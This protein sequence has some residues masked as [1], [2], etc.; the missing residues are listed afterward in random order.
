MFAAASFV[1]YVRGLAAGVALSPDLLPGAT[2]VFAC[3]FMNIFV[4]AGIVGLT[5]LLGR[6]LSGAATG[7]LAAATVAIVPLSVDTTV[8]VRNDPGMSSW[9]SSR[10][11]CMR[12]GGPSTPRRDTVAHL[13][14]G[15]WQE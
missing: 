8:L 7:L 9:F 15:C 14:R 3:R 5:G 6:R 12:T 2:F 4:A 13:P 10:P 1:A 11:L